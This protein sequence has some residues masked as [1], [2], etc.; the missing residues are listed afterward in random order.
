MTLKELSKRI[1]R[2]ARETGRMLRHSVGGVLQMYGPTRV[3]YN[4]NYCPGRQQQRVALARILVNEPGALLL[5]EPFAALD[6]YLRW[7]LEQELTP[8]IINN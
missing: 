4:L 7:E 1:A 8:M 3:I 6:T 2:T 5:D